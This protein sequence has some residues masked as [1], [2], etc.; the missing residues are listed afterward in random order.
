MLEAIIN[1][2]MALTVL[3]PPS[4]PPPKKP[5]PAQPVAVVDQMEEY[6]WKR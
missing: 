2:L 6:Q 1:A 3:L 5:V 4:D